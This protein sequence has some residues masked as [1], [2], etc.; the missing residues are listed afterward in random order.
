MKILLADDE[1]LARS[2]LRRIIEDVGQHDIIGEATNGKEVLLMSGELKPELILLDIR[3]P[4]MDGLE[5]AL[6][7]S[8]LDNPPAIIFTTAFSDH[9][10]EAFSSHAVDYLLK[11]IRRERL[12][13]ALQK[14]R[15][16]NRAQLMELGKND[17]TDHART[18]ISAQISGNIRLVPIEDIYFFQA[19]QKYTTVCYKQG[20]VLIDESLKSLEEEFGERLVRIHRNAL[21]AKSYL[22]ALEKNSE[23]QWV[24]KMRGIDTALE[25][26]RRHMT[27]VRKLLKQLKN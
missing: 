25:V 12:E 7:L 4:E 8:N 5:A 22:D 23:G 20:E 3:M 1:P 18:H 14:A 15:K 17:E 11:P 9:A 21:V 16:V 24:V 13:Q 2:R 27:H 6:H 10:L 19:E 26:S